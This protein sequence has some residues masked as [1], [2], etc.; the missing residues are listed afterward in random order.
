MR[1]PPP[2]HSHWAASFSTT[3]ASGWSWGTDPPASLLAPLPLVLS[4]SCPLLW[5]EMGAYIWVGSFPLNTGA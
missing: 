2:T 5:E 4:F 3:S 1:I